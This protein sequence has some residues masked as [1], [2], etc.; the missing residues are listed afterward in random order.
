MH[1]FK[2][3]FSNTVS[4]FLGT[5]L[6]NMMKHFLVISIPFRKAFMAFSFSSI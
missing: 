2:Q 6:Q 1:D 5:L 3:F 4:K